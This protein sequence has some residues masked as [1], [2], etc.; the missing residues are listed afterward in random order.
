MPHL[1]LQ[2]PEDSLAEY[3]G[4]LP[5]K[6]YAG[7]KGYLPHQYPYAAYAAMITRMDREIGRMMALVK[8]LG[9]DEK[10]LFIFT[11][12]NGPLN[13]THQ[14]LAGTDAIFFNSAGGLRDGKGSLWE[15]GFREPTIARPRE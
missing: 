3:R 2:V 9:L 14:G 12:D 5:D 7:G 1:A 10:T 11:S 6:P 8:E 15:G 13:G 4:K